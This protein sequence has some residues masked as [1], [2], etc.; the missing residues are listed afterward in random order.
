MT[1]CNPDASSLSETCDGQDPILT[2][3]MLGS[4]ATIDMP[5]LLPLTLDVLAIPAQS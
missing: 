5:T 4:C 1:N 2:T 3:F